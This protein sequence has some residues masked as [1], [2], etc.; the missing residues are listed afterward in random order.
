MNKNDILCLFH[1][2]HSSWGLR[3]RASKLPKDNPY[4][5]LLEILAELQEKK[6]INKTESKKIISL[7]RH[8]DWV[9]VISHLNVYYDLDKLKKLFDLAGKP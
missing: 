8:S 2:P 3:H 6:E 9:R 1:S 5:K 7:A 4:R